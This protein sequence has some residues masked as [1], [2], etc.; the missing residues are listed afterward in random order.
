MQG[1]PFFS[2]YFNGQINERL[3]PSSTR[4]S[5]ERFDIRLSL[6]ST[7]STQLIIKLK[8]NYLKKDFLDLLFFHGMV[9][10]LIIDAD[11]YQYL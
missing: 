1:F 3:T 7:D 11:T 9:P 4:E 6:K 2:Q 5:K 10:L 8:L